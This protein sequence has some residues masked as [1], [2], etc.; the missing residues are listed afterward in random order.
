ME[1]LA[2]RLSLQLRSRKAAPGNSP[3]GAFRPHF[4]VSACREQGESL[5]L[6]DDTIGLFIIFVAILLL[7]TPGNFSTT[8]GRKCGSFTFVP[9]DTQQLF[10]DCV[11]GGETILNV[12]F[13]ECVIANAAPNEIPAVVPV[14]VLQSFGCDDVETS[15]SLIGD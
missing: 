4:E 8:S 10:P 5:I 7:L 12:C 6:G 15:L 13:K 9:S 1:R 14:Q 2:V 3:R 11:F